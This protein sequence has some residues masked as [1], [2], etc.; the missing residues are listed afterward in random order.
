[1][2][3]A[4]L[5]ASTTWSEVKAAL[6]WL[7]EDEA[8]HL[9]EY[10]KVLAT[11]RRMSPNP[12]R[13][14]ISIEHRPIPGYDEEPSPEVIGRNGTLNRDLEDFKHM[15]SHASEE[16]GDKEVAYSL[17]LSSWCDW[18]GMTIEHETFREYT[19]AQ[20]I[21]YCLSDMTFHGF[22]EA[23]NQE[24]NAELAR[25]VAEIDAMTDEERAKNLIPAEKVFA[26]LKTK[27]G[28]EE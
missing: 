17:S 9:Q 21:A 16:Y 10:R 23:E 3:F 6:L 13:M 25:R 8:T 11:L 26:E 4:D 12:N 18:L 20:V 22:T 27:Y 7:F 19:S 5:I 15:K 2:T 24:F 1:M 28:T 14:R